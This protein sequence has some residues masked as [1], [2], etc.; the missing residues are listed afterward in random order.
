VSATRQRQSRVKSPT[1]ARMRK[2]H[3]SVKLSLRKFSDQCCF[4]SL[5]DR[6]R[7]P[8]PSARLRPP[9]RRTCSRSWA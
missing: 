3:P 5:R 6:R 7:P 1:T 2:R 4:A 8:G 9:R